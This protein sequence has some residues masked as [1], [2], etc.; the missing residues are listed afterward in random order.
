[1]KTFLR[2]VEEA[3]IAGLEEKLGA[4]VRKMKAFAQAKANSDESRGVA[5]SQ[6]A[7]QTAFHFHDKQLYSHLT[8]RFSGK[9][10]ASDRTTVFA[11][12]D[13]IKR[14]AAAAAGVPGVQY[15]QGAG[16]H[17]FRINGD[18]E[19]TGTDQKTY[20]GI[21]G[22]TLKAAAFAK[23]VADLVASGYKGQ[24]K[25]IASGKDIYERSDN[26]VL[27]SNDAAAVAQGAKVVSAALQRNGV[28]LGGSSSSSSIESGIDV[29]YGGQKT[30]FNTMVSMVGSKYLV[31]IA[32]QIAQQAAGRPDAELYA[33]FRRNVDAFFSDT[34]RVR[35][36]IAAAAGV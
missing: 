13:E 20:I 23:A 34:G 9:D 11:T 33:Q 6:F 1:M 14:A 2:F 12:H 16:W 22:K 21:D 26:I 4:V 27:H 28:R 29:N 10:N 3:E 7:S 19:K 36:E 17:H 15:E 35:Q 18:C 31:A 5:F 32:T 25:L 24:I 30:S 8:A